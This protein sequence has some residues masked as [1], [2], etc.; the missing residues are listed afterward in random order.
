VTASEFPDIHGNLVFFYYADLDRARA[1][2]ADVLGFRRVA[3][4]GFAAIFHA[5]ETMFVTLVDA[6]VSKDISPNP[7][8]VA[9]STVTPQVSAWHDHLT[10][11]G[12]GMHRPLED[13]KNHPTYGFVAVDP[14]G[15]LLEF[16]TFLEHEQNVELRKRLAAAP[17]TT[18]AHGL[19]LQAHITWLYYKDV[20]QAQRFYEE[21][22]GLGLVV[23]QGMAKI[24]GSSP[25]GYVGL[26]DE[27]RGLHRFSRDKAVMF[28][29]LTRSIHA[30][31]ERMQSRGIPI[32]RAISAPTTTPVLEFSPI[33]PGNY[34]LEFDTF[35]E[36]DRNV[37]LLR[38]M[39]R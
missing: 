29:F 27:S 13:S 12:V 32:R 16:E 3:D 37:E 33:D 17:V 35:I 18:A 39:K 14:E 5:S 10:A 2:Y 24:Y 28:S 38:A 26:V 21:E 9:L 30:W 22:I 19:P 1:F 4:Y 7:K 6:A 15:Y 25:T 11:R 8:T 34:Y 31:Q 23:D 20:P 36:D